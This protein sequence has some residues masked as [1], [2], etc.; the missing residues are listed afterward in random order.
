MSAYYD[1][2][3][4]LTKEQKS[5]LIQ[6]EN[7]NLFD[8]ADDIVCPYCDTAQSIDSDELPYEDGE[9]VKYACNYSDCGMT[10]ILK[11]SISYDWWVSVPEEAAMA[12]LEE[13]LKNEL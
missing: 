6:I 8:S 4:K 10:F 5:R 2:L 12:I 11:C 13:E 7:E 3:D 1:K 9:D